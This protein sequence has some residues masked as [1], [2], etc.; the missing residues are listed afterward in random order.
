M[1]VP[2]S[3]KARPPA[4]KPPP[5]THKSAR[6]K[7]KEDAGNVKR[8]P[9]GS[10]DGEKDLENDEEP[11]QAADEKEVQRKRELA[12]FVELSLTDYALWC[13]PELRQTVETQSEGWISFETLIRH[14][15][16]LHHVE[17]SANDLA[18]ALRVHGHGR[19]EMR[20]S[21][22]KRS[23]RSGVMFDIRRKDWEDLKGRNLRDM[24]EEEWNAQTIYV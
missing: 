3:V 13:T 7:E 17:A 16:L 19:L 22:T 18:Q 21:L 14:A 2:R 12:T 23:T 9:A 11:T 5:S 20:L 10:P 15:P 1:F 8:Q 24:S 4:P 6:F